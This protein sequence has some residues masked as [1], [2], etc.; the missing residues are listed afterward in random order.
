MEFKCMPTGRV[1]TR[2]QRLR[3][4][5]I[6]SRKYSAFAYKFVLFKTTVVNQM[7]VSMSIC[8]HVYTCMYVY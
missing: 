3:L 4:P 6:V 5:F 1:T 8:T 2:L 7:C